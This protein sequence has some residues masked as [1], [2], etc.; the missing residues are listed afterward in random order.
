MMPVIFPARVRE[1]PNGDRWHTWLVA[2]FMDG[3]CIVVQRFD[4]YRD[5]EEYFQALG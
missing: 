1:L 5:A 3:R 4:N 2:G